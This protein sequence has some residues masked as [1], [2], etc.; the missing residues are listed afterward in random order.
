MQKTYALLI[1]LFVIA[2][3]AVLISLRFSKSAGQDVKPEVLNLTTSQVTIAWVSDKSY[4]G[5]VY[6]RPAASQADP[7]SATETFGASNQHEVV[8][9]ALTPS[10]RYTYWIG[11]SKTHFQFQTQ[12]LP[13]TP[14][15]F[16]MV[17]GDTSNRIMPLMMAEMPEFIVSLT[18]PVEKGADQFADVRP[19]LPIYGPQGPD[20]VFLRTIAEPRAPEPRRSWTLDWGGLRLVF[21]NQT[22]KLEKMLK[23][24]AAHTFAVITRPAILTPSSEENSG[25]DPNAIAKSTAHA[26][27]VAHNRRNPAQTA[28]FVG[29]IGQTDQTAEID[30][31]EYF[32]I[33]VAGSDSGAVRIDIDVESAS[34]F[35]IDQDRTVALKKPPLMQKRT[36]EQCRRLADKGAYEQSVKAYEEFIATHQGHFQIDDAYFAIAE[37][38]DEKLFRF[39]DALTWYKRLIDEYP[40]GTLTPLAGQRVK[41]LS[42]YSDYNFEPL[43]HFER[44]R[45][46]EFAKQ[47]GISERDKLLHQVDSII[48]EYPDCKLA[49]TMQYWLANQYRQADADKAVHAYQKLKDKYPHHPQ[50]EQ[51]LMDIG[52]TY[53]QAERYKEAMA[54]YKEALS[55]LPALEDTINAQIARCRRNIRRVHAAMVCWAVA[56]LV[57][58]KAVLVKPVGIGVGR[59]VLALPGFVVLVILLWFGAW[60]IKEQFSSP[61]EM[62]LLVT[63]FAAAAA[64]ASVFSISLAEKIFLDHGGGARK[65]P[66]ILSVATGTVTG[67]ILFIAALYLAIYYIN[68]HYL[69]VVGM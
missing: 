36:C 33:P 50:A 8:I 15:S 40:A 53:Y 27:L 6:Y 12:P 10:R 7:L 68:M 59:I 43:V 24:P 26:I 69:I 35:F 16:I 63:S 54:V 17:W 45:K 65:P 14:F 51:V 55:Q 31:I 67:L 60:L 29:I 64:V 30:G 5:R 9:T 21:L 58:T 48:T 49:A 46:I 37:I 34:A 28:A 19:Y 56:A 1:A 23:A 11:E 32:A 39:T 13:T 62:L 18:A 57:I 20:S 3:A 42:R 2:A 44:I 52:Q 47:Q 66:R 22:T 4:K 38:Y 25:I 41:Y 61:A